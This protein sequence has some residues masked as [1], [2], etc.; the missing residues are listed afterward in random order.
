MYSELFLSP[1]VG[2]ITSHQYV[3]TTWFSCDSL[4]YNSTPSHSNHQQ[5]TVILTNGDQLF[6][7][8]PQNI[9]IRAFNRLY[10]YILP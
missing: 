4:L 8:I 7:D 5:N 6:L 10:M 2:S 3:F 9:N 1:E